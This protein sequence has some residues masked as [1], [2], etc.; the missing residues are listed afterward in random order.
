MKRWYAIGP[1]ATVDDPV[2]GSY[3]C[4]PEGCVGWIDTRP[5][6]GEVASGFFAF[7]ARP[8]HLASTHTIIGDGTRLEEYY[9]SL[10]ERSAW[11]S[12]YAVPVNSASDTLLGMLVSLLTEQADPDGY[13]RCRPLTVN[14]RGNYEIHLGGHSRI[15]RQRFAGEKDRLWPNLQRLWQAELTKTHAAE[16]KR[17]VDPDVQAGKMLAE[18][19]RLHRCPV[20]ELTPRE[21]KGLK[22][23]KPTTQLYD[24]FERTDLLMGVRTNP[25]PGDL[26][27][28]TSPWRWLITDGKAWYD[29]TIANG[30]PYMYFGRIYYNA[31]LSS[32]NQLIESYVENCAREWLGV[33]FRCNLGSTECYGGAVDHGATYLMRLLPGIYEWV[34]LSVVH[35]GF[36][37]GGAGRQRITVDGSTLSIYRNGV[38]AGSATNT[39]LPSGGYTGMYG[40]TSATT[41]DMRCEWWSARDLLAPSIP[42]FLLNMRAV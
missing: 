34:G 29:G 17:G 7:D 21:L 6:T 40:H 30:L 25:Q 38:P 31:P 23:R 2:E 41:T 37:V 8:D 32:A 13:E 4:A 35:V 27:L 9:P 15:Y 28:A 42:P 26:W 33:L 11:A 36:G 3:Q 24:D 5:V 20:A 12:A 1:V 16:A 18:L 22:P 14:H 10:A 39:A 19:A